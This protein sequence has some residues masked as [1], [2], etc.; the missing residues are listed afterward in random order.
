MNIFC[1]TDI[2]EINRIEKALERNGSSF[3]SRVFTENEI[4][5]CE[6]KSKS[7]Y[8]SYAARFAAKEAVSKALGTGIAEGVALKDIEVINDDRGKPY[9]KLSG[10]ARELFDSIS[11]A[12][13]SLS[14]SHSDNYAVAF[15]IIRTVDKQV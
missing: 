1:G 14:L 13:I 8:K 15:A 4:L 3:K 6:S 11:G 2:V 12:G 10:K 7:K 9:V 5:Y